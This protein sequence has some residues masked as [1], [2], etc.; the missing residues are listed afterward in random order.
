MRSCLS[1]RG[2]STLVLIL[3]SLPN[4][5]SAMGLSFGGSTGTTAAPSPASLPQP[6][7]PL[8]QPVKGPQR[9]AV[10]PEGW[11][12]LVDGQG[13]LHVLTPRG[14]PM[15]LVPLPDRALAIAAAPGKA[16]VSTVGGRILTV[17]PVAAA[18]VASIDTGYAPGPMGLAWDP[19]TKLLWLAERDAGQLRAIREDGTAVHVATSGGGLPLSGAEDVAVDAASGLAWVT[20]DNDPGSPMAFAFRTSDGAWVR[21]ALSGGVGAGLVTRAG[22]IA[23][24]ASGRVYVTDQFLGDL[25]VTDANGGYLGSVSGFGDG[26]GRLR[27]PA[28]LAVRKDG[29]VLVASADGGAIQQFGGSA[30]P[31]VCAGDSDCDGIPDAWELAHGLNPL[32]AG[33]ALLAYRS[34]PGMTNLQASTTEATAPKPVLVAADP[35]ASGPGLVRWSGTLVGGVPPCAPVWRQVAGPPVQLRDATSWTPAFIGRAE[36]TYSFEGT[37]VC[38][39]G[40][41]DP[42]TVSARILDVAPRPDPGRIQ[43]VHVGRPFQLDGSF[44]RDANGDAFSLAWEQSLGTALQA[45]TTGAGLSARSERTGLLAFRLTAS[46]GKPGGLDASAEAPVLVVDADGLAPTAVAA[47]PVVAEVGATV[48]LDATASV[49]PERGQF[50]WSQVAGPTVALSGAG[51]AAPTFVPPATGRYTFQVTVVAERVSSPAATVDVYVTPA[52]GTLPVASIANPG[53]AVVGRPLALDGAGST[54]AGLT[55]R[56]RQLSGPA[57]GLT[58]ADRAV[59]TVVPFGAG[60]YEFELIVE[61]GGTVG[62]PRRIRFDAAPVGKSLPKAVAVAVRDG[63]GTWI[64]DGRASAPAGL[65]YRWT[66]V[67]G[68]WVALDGAASATPS[69]HA[70]AG[71]RY[72]FELEVDDGSV[73]SAPALVMVSAEAG[74]GSD[75]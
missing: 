34:A 75:R 17:D 7:G 36:A 21:S 9:L 19:G 44:T 54:G 53:V 38:D 18:V 22:G 73:R 43:V 14:E 59:A 45:G 29:A 16:F 20:L 41:T 50:S 24:D 66:Q 52:G 3:A 10:A 1:L 58:D 32:W 49:R 61:T 35:P 57:A 39:N 11:I 56:W 15:G 4:L 5:A 68:P 63:E 46:E 51:G 72:A 25:L 42:V 23:V 28:G 55:W 6:V 33:D 13:A 70:R 2:P 30:A 67:A 26:P 71:Q 47:S 31:V 8:G 60:S 64:L 48:T 40:A 37:V 65:R 27:E 74:K 69:F 62:V 12:Y